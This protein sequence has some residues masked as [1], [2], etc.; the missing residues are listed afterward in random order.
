MKTKPYHKVVKLQS[1]K[2]GNKDI[3]R[4]EKIILRLGYNHTHFR[5]NYFSDSAELIIMHQD[6]NRD[7][8]TIRR[9]TYYK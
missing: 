2:H 7:L 8:K 6:L 3:A 9:T 1:L 4:L 5:I